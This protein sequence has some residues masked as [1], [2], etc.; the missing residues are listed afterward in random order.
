MS[1]P[2]TNT[3]T[4]QDVVAEIGSGDDL[5][6]EF[7]L[8]VDSGFDP[9]YKGSKDQLYNFRN[10]T[11]P[12]FDIYPTGL[13]L[14]DCDGTNCNFDT[15]SVSSVVGWYAL[16]DSSE[17]TMA[18]VIPSTGSSGSTYVT[19]SCNEVNSDA[20][21]HASQADFY[22]ENDDSWLGSFG[23]TQYQNGQYC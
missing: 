22:N 13:M 9:T 15:V 20:Y 7:S 1:V 23:V 17:I 4:L 18:E 14:F 6:E 11:H 12:T 10:Y 5:V 8:A 19:F 21:D 16:V 3:F 2:D